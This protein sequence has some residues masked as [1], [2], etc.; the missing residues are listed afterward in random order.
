MKLTPWFPGTVKPA[1]PGVYQREF[2]TFVLFA[3]WTGRRWLAGR[4]TARCARVMCV[5][6]NQQPSD[7]DCTR[8][9]G[10]AEEPK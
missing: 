7:P 6:S 5:V 8:W 1:R 4:F 2:P 10:L 9:R 3:E